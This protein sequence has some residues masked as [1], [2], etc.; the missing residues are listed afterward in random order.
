MRAVSRVDH[1]DGV[2]QGWK[3]A[4]PFVTDPDP[5]TDLEFQ[6]GSL[7]QLRGK[8]TRQRVSFSFMY[9]APSSV[10]ALP[11]SGIRSRGNLL[12]T[13]PILCLSLETIGNPLNCDVS[14][15]EGSDL[16]K[17]IERRVCAILAADVVGFSALMRRDE[18]ETLRALKEL[19]ATMRLLV[20]ERHGRV[21][22][23]A[24]DSLLAEFPSPIQAVRCAVE[25]QKAIGQRNAGE[26]EDRQMH[27]RIGINMGE[28]IAVEDNLQGNSVNLA[29][30]IEGLADP[31]GIAI[32]D[33]VY[34]HVRYQSAVKFEDM[35]EQRVR[36]FTDAVHTY[37]MAPAE[38]PANA[39]ASAK[40]QKDD[41]ATLNNTAP[42]GTAFDAAGG[43]QSEK[44]VIVVLPFSNLSGDPLQDYFCHGLTN[45]ITTELS[46]FSSLSVVST[47]TALAYS[48]RP[49][50]VQD[51]RRDLNAR[52]V[53]EGSVQRTA[54]RIRINLQFIEAAIDKHV[55]AKR[56]DR[57]T[58]DVFSLQDEIIENVVAALAL[59]VEAEERERAM[60]RATLNLNAY[61]AFLKGS[62]LW[63]LHSNTDE[64][65]KTLLDARQWLESA[66]SLDPNYGR[67]WAWLSLTYIQEWLRSWSGRSALDQAGQL[68]K[69]AILIDAGD[70]NI[71]WI[72]AYYHLNAR[73][74]DLA[75]NEYQLAVSLNPNDANLLAEFGEAL[76]YVGEHDKGLELI[77]QAMRMN[78]HLSEWYRIDVAWVKYLKKDYDAAISEIYGLANPNTDAQ[79]ILAAAS[80]QLAD[81]HP[82]KSGFDAARSANEFTR[83]ALRLA[84]RL[85]G[86]DGPWRRSGR[87][88]R[89]SVWT[90]WIIG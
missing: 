28:V 62:Y 79:L 89:S 31:G 38:A 59:K 22:S 23:G 53:L 73:H 72:L 78:P 15:S 24:G 52:Y 58:A 39:L 18:E 12:F 41:K 47:T 86:R 65:K 13:T 16:G 71:H 34:R 44:P 83:N 49:I 19:F 20:D 21:F 2:A 6:M 26:A 80:A 25:T 51:A 14:H 1:A 60:R 4:V 36:G 74:F 56:L 5:I 54:D 68:A 9:I 45:D 8:S 63:L 76:V 84:F 70:Y 81:Q 43:E 46:K 66:T 87:N 85:A 75:L 3:T 27:L 88:R 11:P 67:A 40:V 10:G 77:L 82:A 90:I 50:R 48:S 69:K 30:R 17:S 7:G 35:G 42:N 57:A 33:T 29:V 37:R 64:T 55:W 61:D 32:S